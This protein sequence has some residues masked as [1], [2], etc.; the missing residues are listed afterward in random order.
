MLIPEIHPIF[1]LTKEIEGSVACMRLLTISTQ[2]LPESL[3]RT[4]E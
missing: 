2:C 4:T 3:E 1:S